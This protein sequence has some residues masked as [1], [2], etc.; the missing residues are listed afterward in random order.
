MRGSFSRVTAD[1]VAERAVTAVDT[2]RPIPA[3]C[4]PVT[5]ICPTHHHHRAQAASADLSPALLLSPP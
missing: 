1:R 4:L 3:G 5:V 2:R